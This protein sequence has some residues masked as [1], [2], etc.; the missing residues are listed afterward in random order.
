MVN[1]SLDSYKFIICGICLSWIW[2]NYVHGICVCV[3]FTRARHWQQ[4][5]EDKM[6]Y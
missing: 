2:K 5:G 3:T 6:L 1:M 4:N